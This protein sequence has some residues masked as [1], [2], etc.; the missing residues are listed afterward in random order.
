MEPFETWRPVYG[1]EGSYAVSD[2][3]NVM[4]F[5]R[6]TPQ[7]LT[8]KIPN[9]GFRRISFRYRVVSI[10]DNASKKSVKKKVHAL[11][12]EAFHGPRPEG[13]QVRHLDGDCLNNLAENLQWGSPAENA[14]DMMKHGR[15]FQPDRSGENGNFSKLKAEQV[16]EIREFS[17]RAGKI[18]DSE[19]AD[20]YG[21]DR[22]T[23]SFIRRGINWKHLP[24]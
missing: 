11:V 15:R 14:D 12:C 13:M 21:V 9:S 4:S 10:Y 7:L 20:I 3:G 23:I 18:I 17:R 2:I 19:L 24:M 1:Y 16:L 8:T 6:R 5:K 22:K